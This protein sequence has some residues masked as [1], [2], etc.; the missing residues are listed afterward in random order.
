MIFLLVSCWFP[1]VDFLFASGFVMICVCVC[2]S[3]IGTLKVDFVQTK[4]M[5]FMENSR[6]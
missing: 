1:Q 4:H 5:R 6:S 3:G 2:I